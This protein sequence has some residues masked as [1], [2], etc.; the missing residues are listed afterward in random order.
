MKKKTA[1]LLAGIVALLTSCSSGSSKNSETRKEI[2]VWT[3]DGTREVTQ[4]M[5]NEWLAE[6]G[7]WNNKYS[8]TV[9]AM[10]TGE[11]VTE[12]LTDIEESADVFNFAQDQ[13]PCPLPAVRFLI[14]SSPITMKARFRRRHRTVLSMLI[15]KHRITDISCITTNLWLQTPPLLKE[16]STNVRQTVRSSTTH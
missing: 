8:I 4:T 11:V 16:S 3:T 7:D 5:L 14:G 12:F 10:G 15:R 9:S 2:H 13:M 6:Q 1:I